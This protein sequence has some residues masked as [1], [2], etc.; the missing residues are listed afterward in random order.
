MSRS[1]TGGTRIAEAQPMATRKARSAA[2]LVIAALIGIGTI[3]LP[4][5][6]Y[7]RG[8]G[9]GFHGGGGGGFHAGGGGF[10][11]AAMSGFHSGLRGFNGVGLRGGERDGAW[12]DRGYVGD[13]GWWGY[14]P[15]LWSDEDDGA[16][17]GDDASTPAASQY[18]Y[19]CA[20]PA[21]YYPSVTQCSVS[22]QMVPAG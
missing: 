21:G 20:N 3:A 22:W 19:Y 2:G 17:D 16:Y 13:G 8:G 7:A 15:D 18:W 10:H 1:M 11:A 14:D 5:A 9:G 6:S 12:R 4:N